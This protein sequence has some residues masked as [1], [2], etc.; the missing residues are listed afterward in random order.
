MAKTNIHAVCEIIGEDAAL[1]LIRTLP[2][3]NG[4]R[5]LYVPVKP[6]RISW[7][8]EIIGEERAMKLHS[9]MAGCQVVIGNIELY[10]RKQAAL[11]LLQCPE[12]TVSAIAA[13]TGLHRST[14]YR[15]WRAAAA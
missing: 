11:R 6:K 12:K 15:N 14:I 5:R 10:E 9:E 4:R 3:Q 7:I 1:K 8:S 13:E 2:D